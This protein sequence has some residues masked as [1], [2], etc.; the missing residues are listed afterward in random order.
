MI[1]R[2]TPIVIPEKKRYWKTTL[3]EHGD[4]HFRFPTYQVASD[5]INMSASNRPDGAM[6]IQDLVDFAP[7]MGAVVGTCWFHE[8]LSLEPQQS[9]E[10][11]EAFGDR[12]CDELQE[13]DLDIKHILHLFN[14]CSAGVVERNAV[15]ALAA[16]NAN[17]TAPPEGEAD[18]TS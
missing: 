17:F 18:K 13:E 5:L 4:F 3:E 11:M 10:S 16:K 15:N 8:H 1:R 2:E 6:T 9:D 12:V 14:G 7:T